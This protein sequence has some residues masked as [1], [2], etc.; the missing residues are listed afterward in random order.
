MAFI[1]DQ[2]L[3]SR[4]RAFERSV[5]Q[6]SSGFKTIADE[7]VRVEE[8]DAQ[9]SRQRRAEALQ[10]LNTAV[11]FREAGYNVSPED[12]QSYLA[13]PPD[14]SGEDIQKRPSSKL[15]S[16]FGSLERTPEYL[17]QQE[18]KRKQMEEQQR[19]SDKQE[20][21]L[22][23]DIQEGEAKAKKE[24]ILQSNIATPEALNIKL[25]AM[26]AE[27]RNKIGSIA[28]GVQAIDQLEQA[29]ASGF[30]PQF[31]DSKTPIVGM[32]ISD[33]PFTTA[34][35]VMNEVVG[36]LQSGA[37][38][39][40]TEIETFRN[41]GPRPGDTPR[42]RKQKIKQQTGFLLSKARAFNLTKEELDVGFRQLGDQLGTQQGSALAGGPIP[43]GLKPAQIEG[44]RT[45]FQASPMMQESKAGQPSNTQEQMGKMNRIMELQSKKQSGDIT[46]K[47]IIELL[48]ILR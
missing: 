8:R 12:V 4:R 36:R 28:Y 31:I 3:E 39:N 24:R 27:S 33:T 2:A 29:M 42:A 19:R 15:L 1:N 43:E 23:I 7:A 26:P 21:K 35:A 11:R 44:E 20:R 25:N 45:Q 16:S 13:G 18:F 10:S 34:E 47:E 17:K 40:P 37:A 9:E 32:F 5:G 48:E 30:N 41:M 22:D 46:R 14:T 38:M 6:I